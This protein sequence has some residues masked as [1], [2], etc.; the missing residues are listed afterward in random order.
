[1]IISPPFLP[2]RAPGI[3]DVA[4]VNSAMPGAT[5]NCPGTSVPEG[6]FPVSLKL[7]WHGGIHIHAPATGAITLPVRAIADGDVVFA[8]KP[9]APIADPAHP[10]NYNPYGKDAA[11]T[12]NG[13][14]ILRHVTDIG[15]GAS[16]EAIIFYSILTHLSELRGTALKVANGTAAPTQRKVFRKEE[17]GMAGRIYNA[18][19]HLH[20]EIVCDDI[21]V[22]K[23]IGRGTG[24]LSLS[25]DGRV[26]AIYG[27]LYF[28]LPAGAKFYAAKPQANMR[29][30]SPAPIFTSD[31]PLMIG[32][33][34]ANGEGATE[35]RG[36]DYFTIYRLDGSVIGEIVEDA[37]AEYLTKNFPLILGLRP[38]PCMSYFDLAG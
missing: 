30:P 26:D 25:Q 29:E 27:E 24:S 13:M 12:D 8:R 28:H 6:S 5:V 11:W 15:E 1:M 21:N 7:G 33:R 10:Q 4:F 20:L 22:R 35:H 34:H 32:L 18:P 37:Q 2:L 16:A 36:D 31:T 23:L 38:V 14:V 3:S 19:D 17:L 9:A